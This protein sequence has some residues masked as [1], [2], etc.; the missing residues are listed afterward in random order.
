MGQGESKPVAQAEPAKAVEQTK[1]EIIVE[2]VAGTRE[3]T[4]IMAKPDA[5]QRGLVH[6]VILRLQGRGFKL[7]AMKMCQPGKVHFEEHYAEHRGKPFFE[8]LCERITRGP[9]VAMVWEGDQVIATTRKM[10]GATD[11][12]QAEMGTLRGDYGL[13]K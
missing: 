2:E 12:A 5:V 8:P 3:R 11:P 7:V 6:K 1:T 10:I 13:S 9:V 4:Y